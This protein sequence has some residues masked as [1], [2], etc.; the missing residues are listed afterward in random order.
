M[1]VGLVLLIVLFAVVG[2]MTIQG[3]RTTLTDLT[4]TREPDTAASQ[5]L[6]QSLAD[7]DATA[8]SLVL[9]TGMDT[10]A[11]RQRYDADIAESGAAITVA[12]GDNGNATGQG[13][14]DVLSSE[15]PVY[16]GLVSTANADNR[17]GFAVG[18]SYLR[19]ANN[20]MRQKLLPAADAL[21]EQ[22]KQKLAAAQDDATAFPWVTVIIFVLLAIAL[23]LAQRYLRRRTN[24][25][26]N[27]GL[28]VASGCMVILL[29]WS[30][31][32]LTIASIRTGDG[33]DHGSEPT[34]VFSQLRT[35][36]VTARAD[37]TMTLLSRDEGKYFDNEFTELHDNF[38]VGPNG[39]GAGLKQSQ[40]IAGDAGAGDAIN[41]ATNDMNAWLNV[42]KQ[43]R[44][45][46]NAGQT[47]K[48][49]Q[50][51]VGTDANSAGSRF[52]ALDKDLLSA[53]SQGRKQ[54]TSDTT[55]AANA[56]TGLTIGVVVLS[57]IAVGGVVVGVW[58]RIREYR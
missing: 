29:L 13:P 28:V 3:K 33:R 49:I 20:L 17:Q 7:A 45:A 37:E 34:K 23:V 9:S 38:L 5:Q 46:D 4:A 52:L 15:L 10:T 24:R 22:D 35:A 48:A 1:M 51:A 31:V 26:L 39:T 50:L 30:A 32:A 57:L 42:H 47:E 6:F 21:Y 14:A 58:Q 19:E 53:I 16:T 44:D 25:V 8:A 27:V 56:V 40:D 12:A 18:A 54:F 55:A 11:L 2:G 41:K 43:I 36:A